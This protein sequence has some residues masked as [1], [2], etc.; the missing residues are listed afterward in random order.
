M[1]FYFL[2]GS[3]FSFF[4]ASNFLFAGVTDAKRYVDLQGIEFIHNRGAA[5]V[6]GNGGSTIVRKTGASLQLK[7][8]LTANNPLFVESKMQIS[9]QEQQKRDGDRLSI[10]NQEMMT[11]ASAYQTIWRALHIPNMKASLDI[12]SIRKLQLSLNEHEQNI[13]SL[14]SEIINT[15]KIP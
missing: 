13:R 9:K 6:A 8:K 5:E 7:P 14:T 15:K 2:L 4:T 11:E 3:F 10:L 1:K 12:E